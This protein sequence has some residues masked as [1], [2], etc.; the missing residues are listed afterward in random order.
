MNKTWSRRRFVTVSSAVSG[1]IMLTRCATMSALH[2][3][4]LEGRIRIEFEEHPDLKLEGKGL[5]LKSSRDPILLVNVGRG[6]YRAVSAVC[7]H[8]NCSIRLSGK[9]LQCPCHGS[10][11]DFDGNAVRGP[12]QRPLRTFKTEVSNKGVE[13]VL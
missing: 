3:V 7:T 2:V 8:L 1:G 6:S 5:L 9:V 4:I 11:F 12:A 13:V 10:T